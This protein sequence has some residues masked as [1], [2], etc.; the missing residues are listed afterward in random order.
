MTTATARN[1]N[2]R[3]AGHDAELTAAELAQL[4][5]LLDVERARVLER[6][7][8]RL[9]LAAPLESHH[10]DELDEATTNQDL[11]LLFRL[12]D[13]EQ[14]LVAEIDAALERLDAGTYGLCEGTGEPI[15]L[16]RLQA[17]PWA[18]FSVRYKEELERR[19]VRADR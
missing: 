10:P 13:K 17:R 2:V 14:Q 1:L 5:Q 15:E 9:A 8:E 11:A 7:T 4:R 12:A 19:E 18:R 6:A 3:H 16:R